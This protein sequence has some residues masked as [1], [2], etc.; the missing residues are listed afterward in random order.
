MSYVESINDLN[1][2]N[3]QNGDIVFVKG[4]HAP[5]Q[6][7]EQNPYRGGGEFYWEATSTATPNGGTI[8]QVPGVNI[9]RWK[10]VDCSQITVEM[11]GAKGDES[12]DDRPAFQ[13]AIDY[14][15]SKGGGELVVP[16]PIRGYRWKTYDPTNS[17][18]LVINK[19]DEGIYYNPISIRGE[20]N[21]TEIRVDLGAG[22]T[23]DSAI[24]L[25]GG[26]LY[27]KFENISVWGGKDAKTKNC[28]YVFKGTDTAYPN[29]T[30]RQCQFYVANED[31]LKL[32]T[33][34]SLLEQ[35]QTAYSKRGIV[36]DGTGNPQTSITLNS[37]YALNHTHNGYWFAETTYC[38]FNSCA[39]DH[40]IND[41]GDGYEAYPYYIDI[42]RGV[43]FNGCGA[44]SSTRILK[45]R[46]AQG[47][48]IN[49]IMTLS[50][51]DK[52]NPPNEL[53]RIEGGNST[54]IAGVWLQNPQGY[55]YKLNLGNTFSSESVTILDQS[56]APTECTWVPNFRFNNPIRFLLWDYSRKVQDITLSNT[57]DPTT[58]TANFNNAV[59]VAY[60]T[61]LLHDVIIRFPSGTFEINSSVYLT[62]ILTRGNGR[63]RLIGHADG[64]SKI[65]V[66]G[67]GNLHFGNPSS[68]TYLNFSV[69]NLELYMG[70]MTGTTKGYNFYNG[71]VNFINSKLTS[72][73]GFRQYY[74]SGSPKVRLDAMSYIATALYGNIE[75]EFTYK[76]TTPPNVSGSKLPAGTIFKA[77][78]PN[79]TRISWINTLENGTNWLAVSPS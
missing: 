55:K 73:N 31:C 72:D 3:P 62:S 6:S 44:E 47:L 16:K 58:N 22:V 59:K 42:A 67:V 39:A 56:I 65:V 25:K 26:G 18:C 66:A 54:T 20:A 41:S 74:G 53:I 57:G 51:G 36:M 33:Y 49:G 17:A 77:S 46:S 19:D 43:A 2:L 13:N 63:I 10:R 35:V 29:L 52:E 45:V 7:L 4:Y 12:Y 75:I 37:C 50:I 78:D 30:M 70:E 1:N 5:N 34:V 9:G 38:T 48:V 61:E 71:T 27:K 64:T 69:E 11:F 15:R 21:L 60:D 79:T 32:Q 76:S 68:S 28:N 24:L 8:F 23:I 40:I 14:L